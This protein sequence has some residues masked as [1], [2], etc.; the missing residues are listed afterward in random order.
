[1]KT[2]KLLLFAI[3]PLYPLSVG[4]QNNHISLGLNGL[5]NISG[6]NE[7]TALSPLARNT[8]ATG[9]RVI[10]AAGLQNNGAMFVYSDSL[11]LNYSGTRGGDLTHQL[12]FDNATE[13]IYNGTTSTW[14]ND[15][16]ELQTFD[17]NDNP[18]TTVEQVWHIPTGTYV[19]AAQDVRTYVGTELQMYVY[20]T[21]DTVLSTWDNQFKYQ[22]T[23]DA[24]ANVTDEV[25]FTWNTST[26]TWVN[27]EQ[28]LYTYNAN[29]K[30]LTEIDQYWD[31]TS[32]SWINQ[33]KYT[34]TYDA[35]NTYVVN[36]LFEQW[37]AGTSTWDINTQYV[38]TYDATNDLL[39]FLIQNWSGSAWTNYSLA[40]YSSFVA[41]NPQTEIDLTWNTSTSAFV[42]TTMFTNTYNSFNQLTENISQTWNIGGFWQ[43]TTS[44][45]DNRYRYQTYATGVKALANNS[46][47]VNIYP[48]PAQDNLHV[49][50]SWNAPQPFTITIYDM[51]GA[52]L[53]QYHVP[54]CSSY[55][56]DIAL[57]WL[58]EGNYF[59]KITG[60]N[61]SFSRQFII[62]R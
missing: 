36:E 5:N 41:Q 39:T 28:Y 31:T 57:T 44:D 3:L 16:Y 17:A 21:W 58:A 42:N 14:S 30:V 27:S 10:Q 40:T 52:A 62:V 7:H 43:Y 15:I 12:K 55:Q 37:N 32:A 60:T 50:L 34:H 46:G 49:D 35:T 59:I 19:N 25:T 23:Y 9:S 8:A 33:F 45:N 13:F 22:Y 48:V 54:S 47:T 20:Q 6:H 29:N 2:M 18:L 61:N 24:S 38:Y 53:Y 1:M 26:S 51:L 4:A 56:A 11:I